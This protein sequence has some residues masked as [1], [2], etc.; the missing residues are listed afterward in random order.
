MSRTPAESAALTPSP[1]YQHLVAYVGIFVSGC[2]LLTLGALAGLGHFLNRRRLPTTCADAALVFGTGLPWKAQARCAM[3]AQLYHQGLV[4]YLIAS[5][6][7]LVPGVGVTEAEWFREQLVASGVP[8]ER[9]LLEACAT[10]TNENT[11]FALPIIN[12]RQ[13]KQVVLV[14]S[15]FEGIRAHLTARRAWRGQGI[16]IY[17]C[18]APSKGYWNPWTWWLTPEGRRLTWYTVPRLFRY[19]LL[20]YLWRGE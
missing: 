15:D 13:F 8:A 12:E 5:G 11:E 20:P 16:T 7:V 18:H 3:A 14:M 4:R 10:N 9:V 2:I 19:R 1:R 6:G 17:D